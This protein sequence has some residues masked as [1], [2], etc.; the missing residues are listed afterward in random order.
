MECFILRNTEK[1][2][3]K[4]QTSPNEKLKRSPNTSQDTRV[5]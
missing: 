5:S 4:D 3:E 2:E 1:Q